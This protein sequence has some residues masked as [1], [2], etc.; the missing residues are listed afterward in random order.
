[1][2]DNNKKKKVTDEEIIKTINSALDEYGEATKSFI[3]KIFFKMVERT[4]E[5]FSEIFDK[6]KTII[7]RKLEEKNGRK[8]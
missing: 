3:G 6:N 7:K 1:M 8:K 2:E 5:K 4:A